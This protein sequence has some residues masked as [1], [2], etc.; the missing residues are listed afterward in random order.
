MY[1]KYGS[2]VVVLFIL[3]LAYLI[4]R[5]F[6]LPIMTAAVI[7][8][9]FYPLYTFINKRLKKKNL[10]ALIMCFFVLILVIL[11]FLFILNSLLREIPAAYNWVYNT[12]QNSKIWQ[13]Y[14]Y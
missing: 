5:P 1:T 9:V 11:P 14:I 10:S 3:Y 2:F 13:D 4:V 7:A 8:Y 12:L 6:A